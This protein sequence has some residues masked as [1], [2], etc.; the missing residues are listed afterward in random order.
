MADLK[1]SPMKKDVAFIPT[2]S[3]TCVRGV[4]VNEITSSSEWAMFR[5]L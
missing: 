4:R 2:V 3:V 1:V 5:L